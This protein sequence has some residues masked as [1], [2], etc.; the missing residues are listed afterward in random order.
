[1]RSTHTRN[2]R[3][4]VS[5]AHSAAATRRTGAVRV[6]DQ[7]ATAA[8]A[9]PAVRAA[10]ARAALTAHGTSSTGTPSVLPWLRRHE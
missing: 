5:G 4:D 6:A 7:A 8:V 1:M 2:P 9:A 10:T 3:G